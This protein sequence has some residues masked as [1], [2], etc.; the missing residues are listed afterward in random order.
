[1][2]DA[3]HPAAPA[4]PSAADGADTQAEPRAFA[5]LA[6]F[7]LG[8]VVAA[9][10]ANVLAAA[11]GQRWLG[12]ETPSQLERNGLSLS[13]LAEFAAA[14]RADVA[15]AGSSVTRNAVVPELLEDA[16]ATAL[17]ERGS[18]GAE[19]RAWNLGYPGGTPQL[20]RYF[21]ERVF[22]EGHPRVFVLEAAPFL[23][24][25]T[26]PGREGAETYWRWMS[27]PPETLTAAATG[28]LPYTFVPDAVKGLNWGMEMLWNPRHPDSW[29]AARP[30]GNG[31]TPRGG[32]YPAA[33]CAPGV[34]DP[35][36]DDAQ[37][38]ENFQRGVE[39]VSELATSP[40]WRTELDRIAVAC[41]EKGIELVLVMPPLYAP[42]VERM[43]PGAL[44]EMRAWMGAAADRHGFRL[45]DLEAD[46]TWAYTRA[47]FR[48]ALHL[49]PAGAADFSRRIAVEVLA[50]LL[51]D[52]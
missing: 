15:F 44:A 34:W 2:S 49:N 30:D 16:L 45:I 31:I 10:L 46:S 18:A 40:E 21:A 9:A 48:D 25:S 13:I 51:A 29:R 14:E 4:V 8:A 3:S 11:L 12:A 28:S 24:D 20:A 32:R 1:M 27:E 38:E 43:P 23:W 41:A 36:R 22:R 47:E 35:S 33:W 52:G 42:L 26:R 17:A 6:R 7:L 5:F 50:P 19:P 37:W 39:R